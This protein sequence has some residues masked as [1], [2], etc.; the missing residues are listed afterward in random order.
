MASRLLSKTKYLNGLQ[1]SRYLWML[2]HQP[3]SIPPVDA[4]TQYI[5]DQGHLVGELAQRMFPDGISVPTDDFVGNIRETERLLEQCKPLF[6]AGISVESLFSRVD[7]LNP[8]DDEKWD[9]IEVKSTTSVKDVHI[10]DV[11]FQKLCCE[12]SG[13]TIQ[14]CFLM[15]INNEYVRKGEIEPARLFTV[16]DITDGVE[17]VSR[18]ILGRID[19]MFDVISSKRCPEEIIGKQC[20]APYDCPLRDECW[21]FLPADNI[22]DLYYGGKKSTD[23]FENGI[24]SIGDIPD[25]FK[26]N[27][28]QQIQKDCVISGQPYI[29]TDGI[30]DFLRTLQYPMYYLDF[31]TFNPA[32]PMFD[33]TRPF[34][35][36]PFQFSL[37]T[38][39]SERAKPKRFSFL[40]NGRADPR[41]SLLSELIKMLGDK[42]SIVAYNASFEKDVL[43]QLG[44]AFPKHKGWVEGILDRVVDL[45]IPFRSFLYYHPAQKGS[46]SLKNVLPSLTGKSYEGM[47]IDNGEDA[48]LAFQQITYG[49]VSDEV[50]NQVRE[51]LEEYCCQDTEGMILIMD[52]LKG[53]VRS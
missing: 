19:N 39:T 37:H 6:E 34:Q 33:D 32:I 51:D 40:A 12:K 9:L 20:S 13:L 2:F 44:E 38:V 5:F 47:S 45:L 50:R 49:D 42:G 27:A 3:S 36:I 26:L 52:K 22:F 8:V 18:G 24:L 11:S 30:K 21:G 10:H 23:L 48:S 7:I 25:N 15:H 28:K 43:G 29:D 53:I 16:Q 31:E 4:A 41:P 46:A 14:K 1:C 35:N 17:D